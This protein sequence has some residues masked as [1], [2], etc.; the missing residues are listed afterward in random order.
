[1]VEFLDERQFDILD[2]YYTLPYDVVDEVGNL[3][4]LVISLRCLVQVFLKLLERLLLNFERLLINNGTLN[5][6]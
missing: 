1:M 3:M 5:L 2:R 4:G 6:L